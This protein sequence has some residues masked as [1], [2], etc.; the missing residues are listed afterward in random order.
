M[1]ADAA[2]VTAIAA[3]VSAVAWPFLVGVL[4][5][6]FR[7]QLRSAFEQVPSF[8]QRAEKAKVGFVEFELRRQ[9]DAAVQVPVEKQGR[10]SPEQIASAAKLEVETKSIAPNELNK[11]VERLC[12]EYEIVRQT[13]PSG[14][15]RTR[16]MNRIMAQMR[17]IGPSVASAL[18]TLKR[19]DSAGHRLAAIAIMQMEPPRADLIWIEE[20][21]HK[22]TPFVF[23]QAAL[24]LQTLAQSQ[25]I[26]RSAVIDSA[27][28]VYVVIEQF[29]GI[30]DQST[31]DVLN[32]IIADV[33]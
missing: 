22:E 30:P 2:L 5:I 19:S 10:V 11:Q 29:P 25:A 15:E 28:R 18:E 20:R 33:Y 14:P 32:S 27:Q 16:S 17:V 4:V 7:S 31:L 21:F 12:V 9:A 6:T 26:T 13:L 3:L 8:M 24:L 23:Y 1:V